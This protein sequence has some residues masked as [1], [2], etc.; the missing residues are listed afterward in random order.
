MAKLTSRTASG[1]P[2][3]GDLSHIVDISDTTDNALGTSK[4]LT[5][6]DLRKSIVRTGKFTAFAGG[7]QGSATPL[8]AYDNEVNVAASPG[9]SVLALAAV[10]D[11]TQEVYNSTA[12]AVD[13]FPQSG[14]KFKGLGVD[15]AISLGAGSRIKYRCYTAGE[16]VI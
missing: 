3:E 1:T 13:V 16:F 15:V 8:T 2:A 11:V 9:D 4:K 6:T 10:V 14:E 5:I 12:N 7:G